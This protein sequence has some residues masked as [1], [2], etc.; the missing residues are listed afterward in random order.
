MSSFVSAYPLRR[1]RAS[2]SIFLK[3]GDLSL[4]LVVDSMYIGEGKKERH[5]YDILCKYGKQMYV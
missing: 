5:E 3:R 2:L 1:K 4:L